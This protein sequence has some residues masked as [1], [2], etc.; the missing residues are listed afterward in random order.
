MTTHIEEVRTTKLATPT[1]TNW[2]GT[3]SY[4]VVTATIWRNT[5]TGKLHATT[6]PPWGNPNQIS[7][8]LPGDMPPGG[9]WWISSGNP[10]TAVPYVSNGYHPNTIRKYERIAEQLIDEYPD[11]YADEH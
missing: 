2:D 1:D 5:H 3:K 6:T 9:G 10:D 11:I 7:S 8:V 4:A